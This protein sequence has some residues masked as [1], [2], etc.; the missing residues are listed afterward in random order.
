MKNI[1]IGVGLIALCSNV[2]L[3][4]EEK[5]FCDME[6]KGTNYVLREYRNTLALDHIPESVPA[7]VTT[8][9]KLGRMVIYNSKTH[10]ME[11]QEISK[12]NNCT[13]THGDK[14]GQLSFGT[15]SC[16]V[17]EMPVAFDYD[18]ARYRVASSPWKNLE[19]NFVEG[20]CAPTE[21]PTKEVM[22]EEIWEIWQSTPTKLLI[23]FRNTIPK[24]IFDSFKT[25]EFSD[26]QN[27]IIGE[28]IIRWLTGFSGKDLVA[29][30]AV[31]ST[32]TDSEALEAAHEAY[33]RN[34]PTLQPILESVKAEAQKLKE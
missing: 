34:S 6:L 29:F 33:E 9:V 2:A 23:L 12:L 3:A 28:S 26:E 14:P 25:E 8:K 7:G 30:V 16:I 18:L 13:V 24:R 31:A 11:S 20:Y 32:P 19:N 10:N 22:Y 21:D 15:A 17:N 5:Y 27:K 1:I 4:E